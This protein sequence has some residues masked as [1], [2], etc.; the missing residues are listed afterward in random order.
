MLGKEKK[1][2][3]VFL[4][5]LLSIFSVFLPIATHASEINWYSQTYYWRRHAPATTTVGSKAFFAGGNK[6]YSIYN[7]VD[8][9]D[10]DTDA[11]SRVFMSAP[12]SGLAATS[13]GNKAFFGGGYSGQIVPYTDVVDIYDVETG[14]WT[15]TNLSLSRAYL[16]A[17]SVGTKVLFAG[18][19]GYYGITD[20]V[21]IYDVETETWTTARLSRPQ[22]DV[23]AT[24]VGTKVFIFGSSTRDQ[25]LVD[26][27]DSSTDTW[28]TAHLTYS[29]GLSSLVTVGTKVL[30]AGGS[31]DN[32]AGDI[33][34]VYED[35]TETWTTMQLP[36]VG[37]KL[38]G[39]VVGNFVFFA[40]GTNRLTTYTMIYDSKENVWSTHPIAVW[41]EA[42][43]RAGNKAVFGGGIYSEVVEF[44]EVAL[45]SDPIANAGEDKNIDEGGNIIFDG[46]GSSDPDGIEDVVSY[47]WDFGDGY[48]AS[49]MVVNH[50]YV[51]NGVYTVTLT[52][53][54]TAG[55]SSSDTAIVNV[56]NLP[57]S[58]LSINAPLDPIQLGNSVSIEASFSDPGALDTHVAQW[59]W[60][61]GII[62]D[63]VVNESSG[64]GN[65]YGNHVYSFTGVY[66]VTLTVTDKDGGSTEANYQYVVIYD[67]SQNSAFVTGG[68]RIQSQQGSYFPDPLSEGTVIFGFNSK[69]QNGVAYP[70]GQ[71]RFRLP[72]VFTFESTSHEWLVVSGSKAQFK[73]SGTIDGEGNYGFFVTVND[74]AIGGM[75][76]NLRIKIW[77]KV[78]GDVIYDNQ[79]EDPDNSDALNPIEAGNLVIH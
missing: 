74:Y 13:L 40:G 71:T 30:I 9:Y 15:S 73:G 65:V 32:G 49:G 36:D 26:I 59:N 47:E 20:V 22:T 6:L 46:F 53:T 70:T 37:M 62:S 4:I 52:V 25:D 41:P 44:A 10:A 78:S 19:T 43:A 31:G 24:S 5:I 48:S 7:W 29:H 64:V 57:A 11:W 45:N 17:A 68:G 23:S 21:D 14:T 76:D 75:S 16:G 27:Y 1:L 58:I 60:G 77:D 38:L 63:G 79:A 8:I 34:D 2:S 42:V 28:T 69:Y 61:D 51:D 56:D 55:A 72:S 12:R 67:S 33:I 66:T 39:V 35:E 50:A 54:D 18:G 3:V